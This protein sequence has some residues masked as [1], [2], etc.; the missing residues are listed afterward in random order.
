V[1]V[2]LGIVVACTPLVQ[3]MPHDFL[4]SWMLDLIL[5][6]EMVCRCLDFYGIIF[7]M[8]E[9]VYQGF[10]VLHCLE[11]FDHS[12]CLLQSWFQLLKLLRMIS[13]FK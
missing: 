9:A 7:S 11:C 6:A 5:I 1:L 10:R 8:R 3:I 12:S 4:S 13:T 2:A